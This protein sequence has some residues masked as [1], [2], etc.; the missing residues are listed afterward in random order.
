[1][2]RYS[3]IDRDSGVVAYE[4]GS[5]Y[6]RVRFDNGATYLYTASSAG[7]HHINQMQILADRGDGLNAYINDHVSNRYSR[8]ER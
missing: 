4:Y 6:I 5:D 2:K 1:M 8:R 3:D 7:Q